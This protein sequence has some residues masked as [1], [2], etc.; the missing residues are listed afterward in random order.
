MNTQLKISVCVVTYN[1]EKYIGQCLKS[2]VEQETK[3]PFEII[4]GDDC[5]TDRTREIIDEFANRYPNLI[6]KNYQNKNVGP[7]KNMLSTYGLAR[8]IYIAHVDGDDRVLPNKLEIQGIF[9]DENVD[10]AIVWSRMKI[11]NDRTSIEYD[12]FLSSEFV[13]NKNYTQMDLIMHGSI[14]C[15]SSKMFRK[16]TL[17]Y[18]TKPHG[19]VYDLFL[20][21]SQL[22]NG[23]AKIMPLFLGVYRAGVG[24]TVKNSSD[25]LYINNLRFLLDLYPKYSSDF[26][27]RFAMLFLLKLKRKKFDAVLLKLFLTNFNFFTIKKIFISIY[28]LRFF[29]L[30]PQARN[31]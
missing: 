22:K 12:D 9:L 14:A 6:V 20:D 8:G 5:S 26:S 11:L 28:F 29:R 30:P 18:L 25:E 27:A 31:S 21:I 2:L 19:E 15:H 4:V 10:C 13:L 1:H 24:V 17:Q 3:F 23:Y 16:E 7:T